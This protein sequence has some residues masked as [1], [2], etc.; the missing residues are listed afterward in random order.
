MFLE[1][2]LKNF[3]AILGKVLIFK[4]FRV[5]SFFK[6]FFWIS[7]AWG[8][9]GILGV[10]LFRLPF[11]WFPVRV[12]IR[13]RFAS[14][15]SPL[16]LRSIFDSRT[17]NERRMNEGWTRIDR[18]TNENRTRNERETNGERTE[19]ERRANGERTESERR[20]NGERTEDDTENIQ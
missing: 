20:A 12:S 5:E 10:F 18:E 16:V 8:L 17:E 14:D 11:P 15:E 19:S 1:V 2:F 3:L 4:V 7:G 13:L 6:V 9:W